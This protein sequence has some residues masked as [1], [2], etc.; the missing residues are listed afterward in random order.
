[1]VL[2]TRGVHPPLVPATGSGPSPASAAWVSGEHPPWKPSLYDARGLLVQ[3]TDR[4]YLVITA[5]FCFTNLNS[6]MDESIIKVL[7]S[8]LLTVI[9]QLLSGKPSK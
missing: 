5:L 3:A 2:Y 6:F 7:V 4:I 8:F 1:M 9:S